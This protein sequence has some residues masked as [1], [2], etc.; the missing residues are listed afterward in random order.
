LGLLGLE[1]ELELGLELGLEM[2]R[3]WEG[4]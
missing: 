4:G 3:G 1:M 2:R